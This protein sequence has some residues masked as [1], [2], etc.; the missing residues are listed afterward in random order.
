[1][2]PGVAPP[3]SDRA[4][5]SHSWVSQTEHKLLARH[6]LRRILRD[7]R[8]SHA[9]RVSATRALDE[10]ATRERLVESGWAFRERLAYLETVP[11]QQRIKLL[12]EILLKDGS[13]HAPP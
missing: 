5:G 12:R 11:F 13:Q 4:S 8:P 10:M 2:H 3:L 7:W 9:A 6:E 1:M